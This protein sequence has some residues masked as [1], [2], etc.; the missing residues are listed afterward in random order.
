MKNNGRV[1]R[2]HT[3][4]RIKE[5]ARVYIDVGMNI[6]K[7]AE[8]MS[9]SSQTILRYKND[10]L[11]TDIFNRE[12]DRAVEKRRSAL[13]DVPSEEKFFEILKQVL[14]FLSIHD[15]HFLLTRTPLTDEILQVI[16]RACIS[17]DVHPEAFKAFFRQV[18]SANKV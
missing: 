11:T 12:V 6:K 1:I 9:V 16:N 18:T 3:I 5:A 14:D 10:P 8:K 7:A 17:C 2:G 15:I 4:S 13:Q